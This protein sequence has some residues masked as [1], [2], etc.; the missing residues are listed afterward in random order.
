KYLRPVAVK[1]SSK[2]DLIQYLEARENKTTP[3]EQFAADETIAKMLGVVP[4]DLDLR[5]RLYAMLEA[6]VGGFYDPDTDSF[7]LMEWVPRGLT[8]IILAHELDHALDDQLFDMDGAIA[9]IGNVTDPMF[10]YQSV[11]EGAG[12][13]MMTQWM[14]KN[15]DM[16]EMQSV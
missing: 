4:P 11:V 15:G 3:P 6:Q 10:A 7:S 12:T 5:K 9:K 1:V 8:K 13:V 2:E 16:A 14:L